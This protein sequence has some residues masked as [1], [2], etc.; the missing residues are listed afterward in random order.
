MPVHKYIDTFKKRRKSCVTVQKENTVHPEVS[1]SGY[2]KQ[3]LAVA[4]P[5]CMSCYLKCSHYF[6]SPPIPFN[7]P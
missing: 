5:V 4:Q 7:S 2:L 6:S 3:H 1:W